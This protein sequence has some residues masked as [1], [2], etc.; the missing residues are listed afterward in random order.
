MTRTVPSF[1][2][3]GLKRFLHGMDRRIKDLERRGD[4]RFDNETDPESA[5]AALR[6]NAQ[7]LVMA[8][9]GDSIA[10]GGDYVTFGSVVTQHDFVTVAGAGQGWTHPVSGVYVL[11]YEHAWGSYQGG[12][13]LELELDGVI[14]RT[15]ATGAGQDSLD[16]VGYYADAGQVAKIKVTQSSGVAQT[17]D[18]TVQVLISDPSEL[19]TSETWTQSSTADV[20][21]LTVAGT[22]WWTTEGT[23]GLTVS[24]RNASWTQTSSFEA[25]AIDTGGAAGPVRGVTFD[26]TALWVVGES[27]VAVARYS[28]AGGLLSTFNPSWGGETGI[29]GIAHDGTDLWIVGNGTKQLRRYSTAGVLLQTETIPTSGTIGGV[30]YYNGRIYV[31]DGSAATLVPYVIATDTFEP[32]IDVSGAT[33]APTGVFISTSGTLYV[34]Q[35]GV[36]VWQRNVAVT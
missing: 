36:G 32:P 27:N 4:W 5:S 21:D 33:T 23:S 12:G 19:S 35:D 6:N 10:S 2:E 14:A 20:W 13:T 9:T 26:G 17:C 8:A 25:S 7:L 15:F 11:T 34:S 22:S 30:A 29:S 24:Q 18:A 31:V 1:A 3:E 28:T 16:V